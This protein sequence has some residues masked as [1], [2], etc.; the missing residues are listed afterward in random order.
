[1]RRAPKRVAG[2]RDDAHAGLRN[3]PTCPPRN[4]GALVGLR[5]VGD[6][7]VSCVGMAWGTPTTHI[8]KTDT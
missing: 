3:A 2:H 1:M 5:G 8:H 6:A 7:F 4:V